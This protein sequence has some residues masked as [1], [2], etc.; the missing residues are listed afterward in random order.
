[1]SLLRQ[2]DGDKSMSEVITEHIRNHPTSHT[3]DFLIRLIQK[4]CVPKGLLIDPGV[5][6]DP[7]KPASSRSDY[8]Y[9]KVELLPSRIVRKMSKPLAFLFNRSVFLTFV[10][11]FIAAQ[12]FF[13]LS[14]LPKYRINVNNLQGF[15]FL[16][17]TLLMTAFA[18]IHEIGH[19]AALS[20]YG[21]SR[22]SIGWGLYITF[23]VFYT[24]LS[25][26]WKL[27]KMQRALV[28]L[29]GI[30]FHGIVAVILC[31]TLFLAHE[32]LVVY[33]FLG[34]TTQMASSMNPFLRMDA[35][36]VVTDVFGI[37][38]LRRRTLLAVRHLLCRIFGK[39]L[40]A[41]PTYPKVHLSRGASIFLFIYCIL[42]VG[43][44]AVLSCFIFY[45]VLFKL[46]PAYPSS[47]VILWNA[48]SSRPVDAVRL[49]DYAI[50]VLWKSL[51]VVGFLGFLWRLVKHLRQL[52]RFVMR[53][54]TGVNAWSTRPERESV[55]ANDR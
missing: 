22:A 53:R 42:S 29:G 7:P 48:L 31:S 35:Y 25:D 3:P 30:Y 4:Y 47:L 34:V 50:G 26:A 5:K 28:D 45:Q 44:F 8:L 16:K 32:P 17:L 1:M 13:F 52:A 49:I 15:D 14:V 12:A 20:H 41:S 51:V 46:L 6:Y 24:D 21:S 33:C 10:P 19:A 11:L 38:D 55:I 27:P 2:F 9:L 37:S 40:A 23:P 36:W 39:T 43:F 54:R 18:L